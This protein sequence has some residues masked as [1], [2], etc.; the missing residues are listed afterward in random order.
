MCPH[1]IRS[2]FRTETV[3]KSSIAPYFRARPQ[4]QHHDRHWKPISVSVSADGPPHVRSHEFFRRSCIAAG[5]SSAPSIAAS[6]REPKRPPAVGALGT[7]ADGLRFWKPLRNVTST[8]VTGLARDNVLLDLDLGPLPE[9][10]ILLE[11]L[12]IEERLIHGLSNLRIE[13]EVVG[14]READESGT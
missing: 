1:V 14:V 9:E 3:W 13:V 8:S 4:S 2:R 5:S 6:R 11:T 12:I 7:I 10:S